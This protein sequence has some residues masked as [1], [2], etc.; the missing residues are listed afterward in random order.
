[1]NFAVGDAVT[2]QTRAG[3]IWHGVRAKVSRVDAEE[4]T[5]P[6]TVVLLE[7]SANQTFKTGEVVDAWK[8]TE[9]VPTAVVEQT[10]LEQA[11]A[12]LARH[13]YAFRIYGKDDL[14][15]MLDLYAQ[16]DKDPVD[17]RT[18]REEIVGHIMKGKDWADMSK[19]GYDDEAT[20]WNIVEGTRNDH[21]EWFVN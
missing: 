20:L 6:Y 16:D 14:N 11:K 17:T 18:F 7:D 1:M 21:P 2:I 19:K 5:Y 9:L 12:L 8:E 15:T 4:K 13:G 3:S 10:D